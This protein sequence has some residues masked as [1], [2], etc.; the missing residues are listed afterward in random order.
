MTKRT[1]KHTR[2]SN[3]LPLQIHTKDASWHIL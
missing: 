2:G 3:K 1:R